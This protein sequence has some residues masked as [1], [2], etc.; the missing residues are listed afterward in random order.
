[1]SLL[2]ASYP[3]SVCVHLPLLTVLLPDPGCVLT[4]ALDYG[5]RDDASTS[6]IL[7]V[8]VSVKRMQDCWCCPLLV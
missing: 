3:V 2:H 7:R 4:C 5:L 8:R 1:M 6:K